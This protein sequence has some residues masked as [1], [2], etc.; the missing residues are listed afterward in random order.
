MKLNSK[1]L[2]EIDYY[3]Y[4]YKLEVETFNKLIYRL[5]NNVMLVIR[6]YNNKPSKSYHF[7]LLVAKSLIKIVKNQTYIKFDYYFV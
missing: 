6:E 2:K 5:K 7:L 4:Y 3:Y 1:L